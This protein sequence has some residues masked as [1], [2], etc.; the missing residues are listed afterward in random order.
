MVLVETEIFIPKSL[1]G[2]TLQFF[3]ECQDSFIFDLHQD[4]IN[5]GI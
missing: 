2:I 4:L 3:G 1:A 5:R